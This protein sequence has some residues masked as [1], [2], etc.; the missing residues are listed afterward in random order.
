[1]KVHDRLRRWRILTFNWQY[2]PWP[3]VYTPL[4]L[5]YLYHA[6]RFPGFGFPA[7]INRPFMEFGGILEESK[8]GIYG[9]IPRGWAPPSYVLPVVASADELQSFLSLHQLDFPLMVKP[10]RGMR[11]K[12]V[13]FHRNLASIFQH[14]Q[15]VRDGQPHIVQPYMDL[16]NEIGVFMI[17]LGDQWKISSLI[18]RQLPAVI[19]DGVSSLEELIRKDDHLF[20]QLE[21]LRNAG[22]NDLEVIPAKDEM[23][24]LSVIGNHRLGTHFLDRKDLISPDLTMALGRICDLLPGF[25]Y[26]RLDIRYRHW[27]SLLQL[28]DF[29]II[30][31]NGANSEPGHIYQ[32]G[33]TLITAWKS[34]LWHHG[35]I[36]KKAMNARKAGNTNL[37]FMRSLNL[38]REYLETMRLP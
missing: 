3:V 8:M 31:V 37:S 16:P 22:F 34:L 30:E 32:P 19:G 27:E 5:Q 26:G 23:I 21:R 17:R 18:Q 36:F 20:L 6:I 38:F 33:T 28:R 35:I 14:S 29:S 15:E 4:L 10:D 13:K 9:K 12:G 1:M 2:W 25:E 7:L 11:G 24:Q